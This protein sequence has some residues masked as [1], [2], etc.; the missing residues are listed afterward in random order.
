MNPLDVS[1]SVRDVLRASASAATAG[2][3]NSPSPLILD[4]EEPAIMTVNGRIK[5]YEVI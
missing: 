3:Q 4:S 1:T 5:V 2:M